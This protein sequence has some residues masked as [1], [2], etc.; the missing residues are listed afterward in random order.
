MKLFIYCAGGFGKEIMDL[1]ERINL[2]EKKWDTISFIDDIRL[3]SQ[4]Y[5]KFLFNFEQVLSE[6]SLDSFEVSIS[7]GE[8]YVRK[9]LYEKLKANNIAVAT[10]IDKSAIVSRTATLDEGVIIPAYCFV[11]SSA[12]I[13]HNVALDTGTLVGHDTTIFENCSISSAVNIAGNCTIYANTY[14]GMGSQVKQGV[15][16]GSGT[17]IG[18]GSVVYNNIPDGVIALGNP[19][20]TV[21][22]NSDK[23]VFGKSNSNPNN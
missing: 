14:I 19:A 13:K 7:N 8:P 9:M 15:T 10:L 3:E 2:F 17:I 20:R 16:I 5:G 11:S 6:N 23:R 22:A 18:M 4:T 21:K 12:E 1:A